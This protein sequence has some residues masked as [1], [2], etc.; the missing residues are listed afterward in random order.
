MTES[1]GEPDHRPSASLATLRRRAELLALTR[2]FFED[3]GVLEV[4]TPALSRGVVVER[5]LDPFSL[6]VSGDGGPLYLHT[7]P[8]ACMKRLLAAGSGPIHQ[9][10]RVFRHGECGSLHNPEFTL[11][12]WYRPG[13]DLSALMDEVEE[14]LATLLPGLAPQASREVR[15]YR[16]LFV[17]GI[18]LDPFACTEA[19]CARKTRE[20]GI[21][22]PPHLSGRGVDPWLDLLLSLHLQPGLGAEG[23]LFLVDFPPSQ[24]S[25]ARMLRDGDGREVAARFEV[26]LRGM[27]VANGYHELLD[28]R[29]QR[30]RFHEA[31]RLR[32]EDGRAVLPPD[33]RLLS[34]LA[35]GLPDCAGVAVGFD[36]LVMLATSARTLADVLAFPHD[37]M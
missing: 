6:D 10:C 14:L 26:F 19:E 7:S 31:N 33:E 20:L 1:A 25:L 11:L 30:R 5:H 17:T 22:A 28:A 9:V 3:R 18:G 13:F 2:R 36:R 32:K 27:E 24:A 29:E 16:D 12:E 8:E 21:D 15:S 4:E 37:R 35:E 34:S 23:P